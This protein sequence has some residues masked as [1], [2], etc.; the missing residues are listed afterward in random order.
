MEFTNIWPCVEVEW[1]PRLFRRK[2][3][4][5]RSFT[6]S[7]EKILKSCLLLFVALLDLTEFFCTVAS[8][9]VTTNGYL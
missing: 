6:I 7:Y 1:L 9:K 8:L 4:I 2:V 5:L 3:A